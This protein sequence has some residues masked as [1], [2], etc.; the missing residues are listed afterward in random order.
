MIGR[1]DVYGDGNSFSAA[2]GGFLEEREEE[3]GLF[4]GVLA[5][6][7]KDPPASKPFMAR[8]AIEGTTVFAAVYREINVVVS[9]GPEEAVDAAAAELVT[10]GIDVP[11]VVGPAREAER[12]ASAWA[13][14]RGRTP[15]LAVDQR[16][17]RLTEVRRPAPVPGEMRPM[18][19][20]DL[21]LAAEW[22]HA[23]DVEAL[24]HEA[25]PREE[26]RLRAERRI[27]DGSLFGWEAGGR[28]VSMAGLAR[29]T[30][31]TVSVNAVYTP[32][33]ERR[34]GFATALVAALSEVGL[35]QGK[36]SCVLYTD[37]ANPTSNSIYAK[38]GY[39]PVCDSRNYRFR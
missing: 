30:R 25:H 7:R 6:L 36:E 27:R 39:R 4:L 18:G 31:R 35:K 13:K 22:A 3:N 19:P 11:G 23:F 5:A 14:G 2:V 20:G 38:I 10:L 34:R 28:L 32:P 12:F 33:P 8:V 17:Y 29:P 9:R 26:A 21:D 16:I 1:V 24:P 37:L 15:F